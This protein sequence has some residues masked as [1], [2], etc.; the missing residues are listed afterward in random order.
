MA[1]DQYHEP[2]ESLSEKTKDLHRAIVSLIEE[3][4]AIDWYQQRADACG[5]AALAAILRHNKNEE[6]EHACMTLEWLRRNSEE[7]DE[8]L[9]TYLFHEGEITELEEEATDPGSLSP[10]LGIGG[11]KEK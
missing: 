2:L 5:D 4:E 8:Q 10:H 9:R 11:L 7:F 1:S 6:V 3:L